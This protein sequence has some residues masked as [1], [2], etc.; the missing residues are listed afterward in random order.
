MLGVF[1]LIV[2]VYIDNTFSSEF[3]PY[4]W[5]V[6]I[7]GTRREVE[8]FALKHGLSYDRHVSTVFLRHK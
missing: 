8:L 7:P 3:H 2:F 4:V 1:S 6:K 5:A